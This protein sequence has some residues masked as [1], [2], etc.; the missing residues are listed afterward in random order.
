MEM[1]LKAIKINK[2]FV[3]KDFNELDETFNYLKIKNYLSEIKTML[4]IFKCND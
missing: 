3:E 1:H 4:S 2:K